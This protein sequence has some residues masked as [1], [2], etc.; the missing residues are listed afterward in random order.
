[1]IPFPTSMYALLIALFSALPCGRGLSSR[2]GFG[3]SFRCRGSFWQ[4]QVQHY[5]LGDAEKVAAAAATVAGL[6]AA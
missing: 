6:S 4:G 5:Y 1:L 3:S 2:W